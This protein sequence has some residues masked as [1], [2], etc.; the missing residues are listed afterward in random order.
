MNAAMP[1]INARIIRVVVRCRKT[2]RVDEIVFRMLNEIRLSTGSV[3]LSL[4]DHNPTAPAKSAEKRNGYR[5]E[6]NA[7]TACPTV[8]ATAGATM[9]TPLTIASTRAISSPW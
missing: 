8:G 4:I 3:S 6:P 1:N 5:H 7:I 2:S 9:N